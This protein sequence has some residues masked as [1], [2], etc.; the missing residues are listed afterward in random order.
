MI[1]EE[2]KLGNERDLLTALEGITA[3]L[4]AEGRIT[5][6]TD[7]SEVD[8]GRAEMNAQRARQIDSQ[9]RDRILVR[10]QHLEYSMGAWHYTL[11]SNIY[12]WA[13]GS[14]LR[15]NIGGGRWA[16]TPRGYTLAEAIV[17]GCREA[18][19]KNVTFTFFLTQMPLEIREAVKSRCRPV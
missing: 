9:E 3:V 8:A 19:K 1:K 13:V 11:G 15:S 10:F 4:D 12:G 6:S 18:K 16:I 17:W 2:L 5:C 14:S 7:T